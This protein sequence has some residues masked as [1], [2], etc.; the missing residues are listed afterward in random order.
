MYAAESGNED[1]VTYLLTAGADP[2]MVDRHGENASAHASSHRHPHIRTLLNKASDQIKIAHQNK[3]KNTKQNVPVNSIWQAIEKGDSDAFNWHH[4]HG[5][6]LNAKNEKGETLLMTAAQYHQNEFVN[7]LLDARVQL[8]H[9]DT[10]GNTALIKTIEKANDTIASELI[11]AGADVKVKNNAGED[12]LKMAV[13]RRLDSIIPKLIAAGANPNEKYEDG[14]SLL[15]VAAYLRGEKTIPILV[16]AGAD[17]NQIDEDNVTPLMVAA[18]RGDEDVVKIL[19]DLGASV[20]V[21]DITGKTA[22]DYGRQNEE[23][24]LL[25][26]T[27]LAQSEAKAITASDSENTPLM[28]AVK[29]GDQNKITQLLNA[30]VNVNAKN[31]QG[32]SA[33]HIAIRNGDLKTVKLLLKAGA[34]INTAETNGKTPP[35]LDSAVMGG[36]IEIAQLLIDSGAQ[37]NIRDPYRGRTP[38]HW[39]VRMTKGAVQKIAAQIPIEKAVK[40]IKLLLSRGADRTLMDNENKT[41]LQWAQTMHQTQLVNILH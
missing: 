1:I 39:V 10:N 31:A 36:H 12:A 17:V 7:W 3:Q 22:L 34:Q 27:A 14:Y 21:E 33:L 28:T 11:A 4:A 18:A 13:G 30:K 40:L 26:K 25:L 32:L 35:P 5:V 15:M 41:A 38:L 6:D 19:L 9:K 20:E 23:V 37:V 16:A 24:V 29:Q 8:N 2:D